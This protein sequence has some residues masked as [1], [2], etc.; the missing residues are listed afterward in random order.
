MKLNGAQPTTRV[1]CYPSGMIASIDPRTGETQETFAELE[2][3]QIETKLVAASRAFSEWRRTSFEQRSERMR[4]LGDL[5]QQDKERLGALMTQEMG[6]TLVS[7]IAEADKCAKVCH[8]YAEHASRYLANEPIE[9]EAETYIRHLPLGVVLAVMPWNF[10]FWQVF[11]FLAPALM[12]GNAGLLKHASNVPRCAL[13]IEDLALRA[14]FPAGLF[15]SLLIKSDKVERVL[16]DT[17]VVAATLTGSEAAGAAVASQAG[18]LIKPTVLELG[19]SDAFIVMPSADLSAA[20]K[21]AVASRTLNNGQ[22]C[23]NAKRFIVH[24][25]MYARFESAMVEA[26]AQ[27]VVG[28]PME[29]KTQIGPLALDSVRKDIVDQVERSTKAGARLLTGGEAFGEKGYWFRP[30]VLSHIDRDA[31]AYSEELFGPVACLFEV[32]DLDQAIQ[33]ANDSELGLGSSVWTHEPAEIQRF[34]DDIEA[35][36]T[37]VNAMVA[38]DP[39][40]PFGGVKKSGYGREL[41]AHGIKAFVNIKTVWNAK[42]P[43]V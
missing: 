18:R 16:G 2:D 30:G 39:R 37:F 8:H 7:A 34:V 43:Q 40:V 15:Q 29:E 42:K 23:I 38:S 5:V 17:R 9:T 20:V 14:G 21:A 27:L 28:D 33:L 26:F 3:I 41:S 25:D 1:V 32:D 24:R 11:R 6:K 36:Q 12:A 13:A 19:G 22:S 31:A 4:A 10:P 35:G